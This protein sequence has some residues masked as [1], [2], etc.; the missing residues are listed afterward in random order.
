MVLPRVLP[1]ARPTMLR[2]PLALVVPTPPRFRLSLLI[3]PAFIQQFGPLNAGWPLAG[4][5]HSYRLFTTQLSRGT[6]LHSCHDP[7]KSSS[8]HDALLLVAHNAHPV[9]LHTHGHGRLPGQEDSA[10]SSTELACTAHAHVSYC[11]SL[12]FR[13]SYTRP[14]HLYVSILRL[15][16]L[17]GS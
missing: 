11:R 3:L 17:Y 2:F 10:S 15:R 9:I 12:A 8:N 1:S 5:L 4:K 14:I 16:G 6:P 7:Q 13:H